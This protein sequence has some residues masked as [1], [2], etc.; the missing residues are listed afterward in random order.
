MFLQWKHQMLRVAIPQPSRD[1]DEHDGAKV[2]YTVALKQT[3]KERMSE[4]GRFKDE[5]DA[6]ED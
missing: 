1:H 5:G 3:Q 6:L 2:K 4:A